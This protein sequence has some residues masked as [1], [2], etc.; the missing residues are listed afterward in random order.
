MYKGSTSLTIDIIK[1]NGLVKVLFF[2]SM[3]MMGLATAA[4]FNG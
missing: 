2:M 3:V 1:Y 4:E